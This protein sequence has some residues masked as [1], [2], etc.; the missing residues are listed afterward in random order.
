VRVVTGG[1]AD[2]DALYTV[3][4]KGLLRFFVRR[5]DDTQVALD[6]WAETFAAAC[7]GRHRF[8]GRSSQEGAAWLYG[9]AHRQLATYH[10]RGAARQRALHRLGLERPPADPELIAEIERDAGLAELR[11]RVAQALGDLS[12]ANRDAIRL[13]VVEE[14]P[15][16]EVAERLGISEQTARARVSRTLHALSAVLDRRLI[17]EVSA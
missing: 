2:I 10:R 17:E 11:C 15:Y 8:R 12:A 4:S 9:I 13:R 14:L 5:T 6:L 3:H 7:A 1:A 16:A